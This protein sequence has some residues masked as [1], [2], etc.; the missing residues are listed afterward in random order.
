[1]MDDQSLIEAMEEFEN[2]R[3]LAETADAME[4]QLAYQEQIGGN[5]LSREPGRFVLDV[6]PYMEQCSERY[7]CGGKTLH[8]PSQT[9][10]S[11]CGTATG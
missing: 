3:G 7:G 5:P 8:G 11:V 6:N 9:R 1:M 10:R 4:R 2:D